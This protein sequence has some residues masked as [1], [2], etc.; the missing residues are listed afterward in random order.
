M[1]KAYPPVSMIAVMKSGERIM[2][3]PHEGSRRDRFSGIEAT[4]KYSST[5][6]RIAEIMEM[7]EPLPE[8]LK[9]R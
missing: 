5:M 2:V 8:E 4:G 9:Y 7:H 3:Q 6:F 1:R